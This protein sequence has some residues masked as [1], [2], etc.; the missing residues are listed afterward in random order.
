M[1]VISIEAKS[2]AAAVTPRRKAKPNARARAQKN[3][4]SGSGRVTRRVKPAAVFLCAV[5]IALLAISLTHLADGMIMLTDCPAWQGWAMAIG[6][7]AMLI[8][9]EF[10]L[11]TADDTSRMHIQHAAHGLMA[12]TLC[13]SAYLNA[14]AFSHGNW[15][16]AHCAA[17]VVGCFVPLAV[18]VSSYIMA[19]VR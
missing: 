18:A 3:R 15:D 9:V 4:V 19:K 1:S 16:M 12:M 8:A 13:M 10:A 14:L 5:T 11:L 17:I 6:V 7:D 2:P